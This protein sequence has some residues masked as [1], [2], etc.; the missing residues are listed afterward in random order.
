MTYKDAAGNSIK[1]GD[2]VVVGAQG[3]IVGTVQ[4]AS[5]L[6]G[7]DGNPPMVEV[8]VLFPLPA[9]PNGFVSGL[10]KVAKPGP[11]LSIIT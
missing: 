8:G 9:A 2:L 5:G 11:E 4:K 3:I 1:E 7:T 6:V 10:V